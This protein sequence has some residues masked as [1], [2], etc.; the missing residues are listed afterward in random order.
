MGTSSEVLLSFYQ[1]DG[2]ERVGFILSDGSVVEVKNCHPTPKDGF[3]VCIE[4]II[5]YEDQATGTFHTHPGHTSNLSDVDWVC[6]LNWPRLL[7]F[8]VG[9]DG[10]RCFAVRDGAVIDVGEGDLPRATA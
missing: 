3:D 5:K 4:D 1:V 7:H 10:V 9:S 2:P 6:Y 8:I